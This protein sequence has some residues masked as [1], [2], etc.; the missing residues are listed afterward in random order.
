M[1]DAH[2]AI[3]EV[4]NQNNANRAKDFTEKQIEKL[5]KTASMSTQNSLPQS[6][7]IS[8]MTKTSSNLTSNENQRDVVANLKKLAAEGKVDEAL[9][10]I[11]SFKA[12][13]K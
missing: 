4:A 9:K 10:V 2:H 12:H 8:T 11:K 5:D 13:Q 1:T 3:T 6:P 7:K